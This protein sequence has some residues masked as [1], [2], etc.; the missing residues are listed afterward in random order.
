MS[1]I[2]KK[3]V[4][5]LYSTAVSM[6]L[7]FNT[8]ASMGLVALVKLELILPKQGLNLVQNKQLISAGLMTSV[9]FF[10]LISLLL[11]LCYS[12]D[13]LQLGGSIHQSRSCE[14]S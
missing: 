3:D 9:V 1:D 7:G 12:D 11:S 8:L 6:L 4:K 5:D 10:F 13:P 2:S 14:D